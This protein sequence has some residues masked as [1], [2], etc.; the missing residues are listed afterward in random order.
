MAGER[1]VTVGTSSSSG[2]LAVFMFSQWAT[3]PAGVLQQRRATALHRYCHGTHGSA[4]AAVKQ[5]ICCH[6]VAQYGG[7]A[8]Q[9]AW[10]CLLTLSFKTPWY[11]APHTGRLR[12]SYL[13][14]GRVWACDGV[15]TLSAAAAPADTLAPALPP[16]WAIAAD[17]SCCAVA[18]PESDGS[19]TVLQTVD[20]VDLTVG[21]CAV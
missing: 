10:L 17:G 7:T 20:L 12:C 2:G 5:H 13:C 14:A 19:A 1:V 15:A 4:D 16:P 3:P 8:L 9:E 18:V 11:T 6:L 21:S